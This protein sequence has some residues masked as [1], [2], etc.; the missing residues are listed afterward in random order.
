MRRQI[1]AQ[2]YLY[3]TKTHHPSLEIRTDIITR[4][5]SNGRVL[6]HPFDSFCTGFGGV[7]LLALYQ[8]IMYGSMFY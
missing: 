7:R 4:S 8:S 1:H 2:A 3:A 5:I 6:F